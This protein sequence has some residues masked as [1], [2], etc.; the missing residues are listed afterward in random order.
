MK[1][2]G[3]SLKTVVIIIVQHAVSTHTVEASA[4]VVLVGSS[5]EAVSSVGVAWWSQME[6]NVIRLLRKFFFLTASVG[7]RIRRE[8]V[9]QN[10]KRREIY[11]FVVNN[12]FSHFRK[13]TRLAG[14][15]P[16]EGSWHLR[17]LEKMG[18]IKSK[19][20]GRYLTYHANNSDHVR[21][22]QLISLISNSNAT[23]I[24]E[25]LL[26]NPGVK[27]AH[28][29][30]ALMINRNT[31]SYHVKRMQ[32]SGLVERVGSNGLRVSRIMENDWRISLQIPSVQ[33]ND[34]LKHRERIIEK[35]C[36]ETVEL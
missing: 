13:I 18:L 21:D 33:E 9:L 7:E 4:V 2:S 16:N 17:I 29:T 25:Y 24:V 23:K 6:S 28:L 19:Y 3:F 34:A 20:V 14:V 26:K 32:T 15:G 11:R 8:N 30:R 27:I 31:I 36:R 5:T 35:Q 22:S 1:S 12:P 10:R